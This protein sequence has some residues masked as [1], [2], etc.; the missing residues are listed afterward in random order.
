MAHGIPQSRPE[1]VLAKSTLPSNRFVDDLWRRSAATAGVSQI[2]DGAWVSWRFAPSDNQPT[3]NFVTESAS[4]DGLSGYIVMR[5]KKV[6]RL[7]VCFFVDGLCP[8]GDDREVGRMLGSACEWARAA[9]AALA[10]TYTSPTAPWSKALSRAKFRRLPRL[11]DPRP[12]HVCVR[13]HP[14]ARDQSI[15]GDPTAWRLTLADSDLV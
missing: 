15:L 8:D 14:E 3:Y 13:I 10:I 7:S 5:L 1:R 11:L 12:C 2:R 6:S 4:G 9:A